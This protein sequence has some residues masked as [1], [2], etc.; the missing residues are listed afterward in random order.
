MV[1]GHSNFVWT[2]SR[3]LRDGRLY[4]VSFLNVAIPDAP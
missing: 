1:I 4:R 3:A 2:P